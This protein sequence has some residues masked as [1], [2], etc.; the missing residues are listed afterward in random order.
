MKEKYYH[1]LSLKE[2]K[3]SLNSFYKFRIL[4][5]ALVLENIDCNNFSCLIVNLCLLFFGPNWK[6]K[7]NPP[8]YLYRELQL[9][10]SQVAPDKLFLCSFVLL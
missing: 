1:R 2:L 8:S 5:F 3:L 10:V 9:D 4:P 6:S 7:P